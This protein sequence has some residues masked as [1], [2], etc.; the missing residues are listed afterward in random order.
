[1]ELQQHRILIEVAG[2]LQ[3]IGSANDAEDHCY[4]EDAERMR[5]DACVSLCGLLEEYP[6]LSAFLPGLRQEL[7]TGHILGFG[8]SQLLSELEIHLSA[9]KE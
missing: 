7:D 5:R 1:M 9:L 6:F 8:W 3:R 4:K 2:Y